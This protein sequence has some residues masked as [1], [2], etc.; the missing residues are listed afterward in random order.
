M[1]IGVAG[2][3]LLASPFLTGIGA[4]VGVATGLKAGTCLTAEAAKAKGYVKPEQVG[5]LIASAFAQMA[6]RKIAGHEEL[7]IDD[8]ACQ[9]FIADLKAAGGK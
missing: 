4:G 2:S 8:A 1:V 5:D 9:K 7:T 3:L 6:D